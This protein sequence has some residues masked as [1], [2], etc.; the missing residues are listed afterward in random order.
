MWKVSLHVRTLSTGLKGNYSRY[1]NVWLHRL[2]CIN[3]QCYGQSSFRHCIRRTPCT[4]PRA[5]CRPMRY[6]RCGSLPSLTLPQPVQPIN[7]VQPR[8]GIVHPLKIS[9]ALQKLKRKLN[10]QSKNMGSS[11]VHLLYQT[12]RAPAVHYFASC[13][14]HLAKKNANGNLPVFC[15]PQVFH[16]D[17]RLDRAEKLKFAFSVFVPLTPCPITQNGSWGTLKAFFNA[18]CML[19]NSQTWFLHQL[20]MLFLEVE[21]F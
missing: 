19:Q 18:W 13:L 2:S 6:G 21:E 12:R 11:F 16:R 7:V 4:L 17:L 8:H 10:Q 5:S 14:M 3:K 20:S 9:K 1:G 15:L